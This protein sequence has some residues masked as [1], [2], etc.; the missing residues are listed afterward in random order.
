MPIQGNLT[1]DTNWDPENQS[2]APFVRSTVPNENSGVAP[3][4]NE[5]HLRELFLPDVVDLAD[6]YASLKD[7]VN[8]LAKEVD[9]LDHNTKKYVDEFSENVPYHQQHIPALWLVQYQSS[10]NTIVREGSTNGITGTFSGGTYVSLTTQSFT[11]L[12]PPNVSSLEQTIAVS[13]TNGPNSES[14]NDNNVNIKIF[15]TLKNMNGDSLSPSTDIGNLSI[16]VSNGFDLVS[17]RSFTMP[18]IDFSNEDWDD[19]YW[20]IRLVSNASISSSFNNDYPNSN[21]RGVKNIH[22]AWF[23]TSFNHKNFTRAE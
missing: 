23:S 10:G 2:P 14:G 21:F 9:S 4:E 20:E 22:N 11:T 8:A 1:L 16:N 15:V 19:V 17:T 6:T 7:K 12:F 13:V 18:S 3:D 5:F